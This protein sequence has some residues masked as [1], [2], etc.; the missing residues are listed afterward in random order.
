MTVSDTREFEMTP[1]S[2][3]ILVKFT[4]FS[5]ILTII[6]K[7]VGWKLG[8]T[9]WHH[10]EMRYTELVSNTVDEYIYFLRFV[11]G[12]FLK[13]LLNLLQHCICFMFWFFSQE[14]CRILA[15]WPGIEPAPPTIGKSFNYWTA[16]EVP[17]DD[18]LL[19]TIFSIS[20]L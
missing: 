16:R 11:Y 5:A 15:S 14:T 18:Y 1:I 12:P 2:K 13:S 8:Y 20:S 17:A 19:K 7:H 10:Q 4:L 9:K 6:I 3:I